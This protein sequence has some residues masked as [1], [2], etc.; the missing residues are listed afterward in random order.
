MNSIQIRKVGRIHGRSL[1]LRN[2]CVTDAKFILKLRMDENK[3]RHISK[4]SGELISQ[5]NWLEEYE[6]S[7]S[8]AYF[9][10]E[11]L[12]GIPLG[13]VRL[14]DARGDSFCWGS[15]ILKDG[16]PVNAAI[17]SALMVYSYALHSL[18][19]VNA[20]FQVHKSNAHVCRFHER[21]GAIR[22]S[23]DKIQYEYTI[24]NLAINLSMEK[25]LRYLPNGIVIEDMTK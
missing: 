13:T 6:K 18:G 14:Y 10:I 11:N 9:I 2:A 20:H 12:Y 4:I 1:I 22:V 3:S 19:F 15:W 21:F 16:V 8:E 5:Q 24:S 23:E 25:Y 17:E 7:N